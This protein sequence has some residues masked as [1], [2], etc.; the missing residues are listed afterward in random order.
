M[1][2]E[3]TEM[4]FDPL[5]PSRDHN[6]NKNV[7]KYTTKTIEGSKLLSLNTISN[8][9]RLTTYTPTSGLTK[10]MSFKHC[11]LNTVKGIFYIKLFF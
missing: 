9:D 2:I 5:I 4:N 1:K 3:K 6:S 7:R 10:R 11:L 8:F